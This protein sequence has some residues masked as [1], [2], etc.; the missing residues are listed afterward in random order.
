MSVLTTSDGTVSPMREGLRDGCSVVL[1]Y[2]P[3]ALA[4]GTAL[5]ST[6]V[7]PVLAWSSSWLVMAG[8]A[9][10]I[11]VQLLSEGSGA[12]VV[13]TVA[14]VVNSR[15]L[16]YS[17]ALAPHTAGWTRRGRALAAYFLA[18]PVYALAAARFQSRRED[19]RARLQYY[20]AMA[21]TCWVGWVT[22][23]AA[24]GLLS[25]RLPDGL[26]L[27]LAAPLTFLLLLAPMLSSRAARVSAGVAATMALPA[28]L[29][30]LG[31]G[32]PVAV[33]L[34]VT[35]GTLTTRSRDA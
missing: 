22:L 6:A 20:L 19:A 10:L 2:V 28:T 31:L 18:D 13:V 4:L 24:G 16:L 17:A 26:P 27:D 5:V 9:Q 1:G 23:T 32:L 29:L 12:S 11:A 3:F 25:G 14:L 34:G 30:P 21:A 33:V 7:D 35:A 8:A 15:H